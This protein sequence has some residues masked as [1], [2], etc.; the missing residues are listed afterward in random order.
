M[1]SRPGLDHIRREIL[2]ACNPCAPRALLGLGLK[3][4][5]HVGILM[6]NC[7]D[8]VALYYA[9]NL[10]GARAVLLNARYRPDDLAYVIPKAAV[11]CLFV[12]DHAWEHCDYRPMLKSVFPAL[13][14]W[15]GGQ[16]RLLGSPL[17]D[18]PIELG[19][20]RAG[21]WP[22]EP[23]LAEAA[24][25]VTHDDVLA[26]AAAVA[27]ADVG[28]LIFSSGTTSRPKA[29]MLTHLSLCQTG[30]ALAERFRLMSA[31]S[32]TGR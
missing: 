30:A 3:R 24:A 5:D 16:L 11:R 28:P 15:Q 23:A 18:I 13:A 12:G 10:I 25:R 1:G 14:D 22:A 17:L 26:A 8:Y 4:G 6:P 31:S 21:M 2:I 29:C 19:D 7:W 20:P 32:P 9:I 27:P